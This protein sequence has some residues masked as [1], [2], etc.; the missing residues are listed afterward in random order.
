MEGEVGF[1]SHD[2]RDQLD[3]KEDEQNEPRACR[4]ACVGLGPRSSFALSAH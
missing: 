4:H 3:D 1:H 2:H